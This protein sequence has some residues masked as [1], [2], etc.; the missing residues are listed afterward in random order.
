MVK[1]QPKLQQ[2]TNIV[3]P[4]PNAFTVELKLQWN[5]QQLVDV[6]VEEVQLPDDTINTNP[7][8]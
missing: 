3:T 1:L 4:K 6:M 2:P 8:L 5:A 7:Q